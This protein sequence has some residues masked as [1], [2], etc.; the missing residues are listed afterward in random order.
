[1]AYED[2]KN[3]FISSQAI[4][5]EDEGKQKSS[6]EQEMEFLQDMLRMEEES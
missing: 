1:M 4:D 5:A 2:R 3:E 6:H